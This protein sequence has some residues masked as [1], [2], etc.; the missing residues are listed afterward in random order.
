LQELDYE[1]WRHAPVMSE[2][3]K[4]L[5]ITAFPL[6]AF[7]YMACVLLLAREARRQ[8]RLTDARGVPLRFSSLNPLDNLRVAKFFFGAGTGNPKIDLIRTVGRIL[9]S[10]LFVIATFAVL[11]LIF[12]Q[13][14]FALLRL[15]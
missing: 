3:E 8:G 12:P 2:L 11:S 7:S 4:D 13:I 5:I 10:I 6:V 9:F 14:G 15:V 1:Q